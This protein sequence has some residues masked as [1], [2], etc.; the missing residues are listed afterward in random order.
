[1]RATRYCRHVSQRVW[2]TRDLSTDSEGRRITRYYAYEH[3]F[4]LDN[5]EHWSYSSKFC[6]ALSP[7]RRALFHGFVFEPQEWRWS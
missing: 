6:A 7:A 4:I 2:H 3:G 1:M 5:P